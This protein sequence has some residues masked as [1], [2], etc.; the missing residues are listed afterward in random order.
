MKTDM[1]LDDIKYCLNG[2]LIPTDSSKL[3][4]L[5][6]GV[7]IDIRTKLDYILFEIDD[8]SV[9]FKCFNQQE[10]GL[11]NV[12]DYILFTIKN[13]TIYGIAI[14]LKG[15][16]SPI[17]QLDQ[18]VHL[19][20]FILKRIQYKNKDSKNVIIRKAAFLKSDNKLISIKSTTAKPKI[21]QNYYFCETT[22]YL[23]NI[24]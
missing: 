22:L 3:Q 19:I 16:N 7:S 13:N 21:N 1:T 15:K 4:D 9:N 10:K 6:N 5:K 8:N 2:N 17:N 12:S 11:N 23:A 20:S 18:T 24:I 14:E